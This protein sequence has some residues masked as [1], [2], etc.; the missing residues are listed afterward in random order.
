M[1]TRS[2]AYLLRGKMSKSF[3]YE[4]QKQLYK[5][6][7][8]LAV[9]IF[10][11]I[12]GSTA[13]LLIDNTVTDFLFYSNPVGDK[14]LYNIGISV[15]AAYI[16][17]VFQ[18]YMPI[19]RQN[20][21]KMRY[22]SEANRHQIYILEQ[23]LKAWD[24][25]IIEKRENLEI[26]RF[27]KFKEFTYTTNEG[28]QTISRT[29]YE[30]T[31]CELLHNLKIIIKNPM[32]NELDESYR[33]LI[34]NNYEF[35]D[36]FIKFNDL[37]LVWNENEIELDGAYN[38]IEDAKCKI[39]LFSQKLQKIENYRYIVDNEIFPYEGENDTQKMVHI[40]NDVNE[41]KE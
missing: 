31:I 25:F 28:R 24:E 22:V 12:R 8:V 29:L 1:N 6:S 11:V 40:L 33:D 41:D 38:K 9:S 32:F 26:K 14:T 34:L 35:L 39:R 36:S 7:L 20:A 5:L 27:V 15:I 2:I 37:F 18:V 30:E 17:Y 3:F 10:V 21:K 16:F 13:P 19:R 4:Y 23:F